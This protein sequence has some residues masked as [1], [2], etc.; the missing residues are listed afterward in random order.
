MLKPECAMAKTQAVKGKEGAQALLLGLPT[1]ALMSKVAKSS[2][3]EATNLGGWI[4]TSLM[5][6]STCQKKNLWRPA[7]NSDSCL[8][9]LPQWCA[10]ASDVKAP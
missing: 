6:W 1:T 3:K 9:Y 4:W 7:G 5:R 8:P 10:L 2:Q